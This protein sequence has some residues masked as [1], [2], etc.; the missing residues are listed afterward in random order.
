MA[1]DSLSIE[2]NVDQSHDITYLGDW[3]FARDEFGNLK[4]RIMTLFPNSRTMVTS[5]PTF[6]G[7]Q[8]ALYIDYLNE[9]RRKDNQPKLTQ[10]QTDTILT[11]GVALTTIEGGGGKFY[12]IIRPDPENMQLAYAADELLQTFHPKFRI[13]FMHTDNSQVRQ[14][15]RARGESWRIQPIPKTMQGMEKTIN[16][17]KIALTVPNHRIYYYNMKTGSRYLTY[18]NFARL[19]EFDTPTLR[20]FL[21]EIKRYCP[22]KN[23]EGSEELIFFKVRSRINVGAYFQQ[24]DFDALSDEQLRSAHS[25]LC[26]QFREALVDPFFQHNNSNEPEW[27]SELFTKLASLDKFSTEEV[28]MGLCDEFALKIN[29]L[30]GGW[31]NED[32]GIVKD[33]V[34]NMLDS[35]T[36]SE[37][38]RYDD[39]IPRKLLQALVRESFFIEYANI[40][41]LQPITRRAETNQGEENGPKPRRGVYIMQTKHRDENFDR[42]SIIR[43]QKWGVRE[44]LDE[45][46]NLLES[47][48]RAEEYT[49]YVLNRRLACHL[50]QMNLPPFLGVRR[51]TELYQG[52]QYYL[53]DMPIHTPYFEREYVPGIATYVLQSQFFQN[54][55]FGVEFARLLGAAAAPNIIVGRSSERTKQPIF[56]DGDEVLI[57]DENNM[58]K[59]IQVSEQPGTF[60]YYNMPME[61]Q[62]A[63]YAN[64]LNKRELFIPNPKSVTEAFVEAFR[65]KFIKIQKSAETYRKTFDD[66]PDRKNGQIAVG[67]MLERWH[68]VLNRLRDANVDQLTKLLRDNITLPQID[69]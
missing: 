45:G 10:E 25:R 51:I 33:P 11:D 23:R 59:E 27:L 65:E 6:H 39:P 54:P 40:G 26:D 12:I 41:Y 5:P 56:D 61:N 4:T 7:D 24:F 18:E 47:F 19:A 9:K 52:N 67:S 14:A 1:Q 28:Q 57:L 22:L 64:C 36:K 43:L 32:G 38:E 13:F 35:M 49:D 63:D 29:W 42:I 2:C 68:C 21:K 3:L 20:A 48:T 60:V 69:Y 46:K 15:I 44:M 30:P 58:P 16:A 37:K 66:L 34:F 50:L 55:Q 8:C 62:I 17:S 31:L 53:H